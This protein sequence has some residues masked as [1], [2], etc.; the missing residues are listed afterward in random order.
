MTLDELAR[1]LADAER[2]VVVSGAGMSAESGVP[3]FRDAQSG[4]WARFDASTLATAEAWR[5]DPPLVWAWYVWRMALVRQAQPHAGHAA[6]TTL[7]G[8][9]PALQVITQNVD[10]LH[11]RA[12][13]RDVVHLH[14]SLF[15]PRCFGC[16]TPSAAIATATLSDFLRNPKARLDPPRCPACG[17]DI[18]PGV[19]W[20]GEPLPRAEWQ[21]AVNAVQA[22]EVLLVVGTSGVVHPAAALP[23]LARE[24]GAFV[25][26][27]NPQPSQISAVADGVLRQRA[28]EV[29]AE[30]AKRC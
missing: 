8:R 17:G 23:A 13:T 21:C 3:T 15:K 6:I 4:L 16:G 27:V 30:V 7:Q 19:V 14:G 20:F 18:R 9:R 26:E 25:V 24:A 5:C 10:D 29:L 2:I 11:E 28:A 12:G 22:A 1:R